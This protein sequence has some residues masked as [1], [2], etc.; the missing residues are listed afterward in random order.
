MPLVKAIGRRTVSRLSADDRISN[1]KTASEVR[2]QGLAALEAPRSLA[3]EAANAIREQILTGG[4][5]PGERLVE[6]RIAQQLGVSRGP[7]REA[8]KLL[9]AEGLVE[10]EPRKG[11][12]VAS[13]TSSDVKDI[14]ELR[15]AIEAS[16]ARLVAGSDD[17]GSIASLRD[18]FGA[19]E[20]AGDRADPRAAT[21][22]D[23]AFHE[24][25][26]R[27][28]GNRRLYEV[29]VKYVPMIRALL[30]L[31]EHL[32]RSPHEVREQHRPILEA[33]EMR[34]PDLAAARA[35]DHCR[36]ASALVVDFLNQRV[37]KSDR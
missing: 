21:H 9:G 24:A 22:A 19:L 3:E 10:E 17:D 6:A 18:A 34:D 8:F 4:F 7:V 5:L 29:W 23:L 36:E 20:E 33:I 1:V 2:A 35:E 31:D 15:A 11:T 32:L 13:V 27:L 16:A 25:L 30:R 37:A 12:F 28:S 26:C 14:Y